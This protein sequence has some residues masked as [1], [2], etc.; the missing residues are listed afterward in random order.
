MDVK[1]TKKTLNNGL[2]VIFVEDHSLP[3][4]TG[5]VQFDVG[6]AYER[7]GITGVSHLLE[8]MLFK[9]TRRLGTIDFKK[10]EEL[11]KKLWEYYEKKSKGDTTII[12]EIEKIEEEIKKLVISEEIWKIYSM[13]GGEMMNASTGKLSTQYYVVLPSNKKELWAKIESDRFQ[14][15]FLREFYS[16]RDV[17][18]EERR[19]GEGRP[20]ELFWDNIILTAYTVSSVRNPVIGWETDI[21]NIKPEEVLEYYRNYYIPERCIILLGGDV[22][23]DKDIKLVE[24]YFGKWEKRKSPIIRFTEE[25]EQKTERRNHIY[26]DC[27]PLYSISFL[28]PKL[29]EREYYAAFLLSNILGYGESSLL[30]KYLVDKGIATEVSCFLQDNENKAPSLFI[31]YIYPKENISFD[32]ITDEIFSLLDS[33]KKNGISDED[34]KKVKIRYKKRTIERMKNILWFSFGILRGERIFGDPE[35]Y[36]KEFE[37]IDSIKKEE[38]LN[39][40]EKYLVKDRSNIVTMGRNR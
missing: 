39:I 6:G 28:T 3:V 32:R 14:N 24:K 27:S 7:L 4:F 9:G 13:H 34:L 22:Y 30:K 11:T 21:M 5:I 1:I 19:M 40:I 37:I 20:E 33:L 36:K 8:H 15:L 35:Y 26:F 16:E 29:G 38:C 2:R 18:N 23:P 25:L 12:K 17:V 10:E 31:F